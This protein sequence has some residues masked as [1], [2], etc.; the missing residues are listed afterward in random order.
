MLADEACGVAR[1]EGD[2][3]LMIT[4]AAALDRAR[5]GSLTFIKG[6][7]LSDRNG[8]GE[9]VAAAIVVTP[10][11]AS[12]L[13][14]LD[15]NALLVAE[16]TRL[17]FM[18]LV[19]KYFPPERPPAGIHPSSIV[20]P[21]SEISPGASIGAFC[22]IG[23]NCRVGDESILHPHV[24]LLQSVAVGRKVTIHSG[25]VLGAEGFGYERADDGEMIKFPHLGGIVVED[26]VEIGSNT[27]ID[28]GS[29]GDTR[30][31][32]GCKIDNQIHVAHNVTV[33]ENAVVIAQAMLGGSASIGAR[34]WIAPAGIV[35]NQVRVG[36]DAMVGLAA[37]V[38][39]DVAAGETVMGSPAINDAE[40][41]RQRARLKQLLGD[42]AR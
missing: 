11:L 16:N 41:K 35:M 28:R 40:F 4:H 6:D 17:A 13:R 23:P 26:D 9:I 15:R 34:A 27:S 7:T 5:K 3:A 1:I 42:G 21:S 31:C 24:T 29:L 18:R 2:T 30:L 14:A 37:V 36:D 38:T 22:F 20:D 39:K 19:A 32:R 10:R 25:S 33:G 8:L 12:R